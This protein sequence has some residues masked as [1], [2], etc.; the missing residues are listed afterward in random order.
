MYFL[1]KP[2][3][4]PMSLILSANLGAN[5]ITVEGLGF[6]CRY[7]GLDQF[8]HAMVQ[9]GKSFSS[10]Y[11]VLKWM[12]STMVLCFIDHRLKVAGNVVW[13]EVIQ[14]FRG[15]SSRVMSD[16]AS[17]PPTPSPTFRSFATSGYNRIRLSLEVHCSL[18]PFE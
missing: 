6:I 11:T 1:L 10:G 4:S 8:F 14:V 3:G 13:L 7:D 2:Y 18:T 9:F 15:F 5:Y 12:S 17:F 16:Q